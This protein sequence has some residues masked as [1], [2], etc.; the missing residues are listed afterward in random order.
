VTPRELVA[1]WREQAAAYERDGVPAATLL[2][3]VANELEATLTQHELEKLT[4][5]Q[6]AAES[7]YSESQLRRRFPGQHTIP[8]AKLPHKGTREL[9]PALVPASADVR[10]P[11]RPA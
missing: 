4:V 10:K 11:R 1:A 2:R 3:R 9:G 5:A 7:G 8:R 6:A